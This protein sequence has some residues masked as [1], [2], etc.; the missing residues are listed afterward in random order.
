MKPSMLVCPHDTANNPG[1]WYFITQYAAMEGM[2]IRFEMSLDFDEF[3]EKLG[4]VD[5]VYSNPQDSVRLV[6]EMG[7]TP[8]ARPSGIYD[9]IVLIANPALENPSLTA[10]NGQPL[11]TVTSLLATAVG[12]SMLENQSI[13]PSE[14][15]SADTWLSVLQMVREGDVSY[16][17][18][19]KDTYEGL[20]E[21][22]QKSVTNVCIS[23]EQSAFHSICLGQ[24]LLP[25]QEKW[26][27]LF[28]SMHEN[29]NGRMTLEELG[30]EKWLPVTSAEF[31]KV[32]ALHGGS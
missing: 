28:L 6:T 27:Q 31:D 15:I 32:K 19:Y 29:E 25:E 9:E 22:N 20:S 7:F 18:M 2:P 1:R 17:F 11:A 5:I 12:I 21:D 26:T 14:I 8:V 10:V 3:R 30:I 24:R 13:Q 16:G 4:D 23:T